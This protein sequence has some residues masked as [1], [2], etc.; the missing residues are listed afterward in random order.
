MEQSIVGGLINFRGLVYSP[1][2]EQGVVFLFGRILEDLNMYIEEVRTKYPDCVAR[3]YTG[4]GWERVYIEFEFKSSDFQKHEHDKNE[5]NIIVCWEH[6]W[7]ECPLEVIELKSLIKELPSIEIE[8]PDKVIEK[9]EYSLEDHYKKSRVSKSTQLLYEKLHKEIG[10]IDEEIWRKFSKTMITYYSP[11]KLFVSVRFRK[12]SLHIHVFTNEEKL[13]GVK[14]IKNHTNWGEIKL[15][16]E[17]N[18]EMVVGVIK[19]SFEVMKQAIKNNI[20]TGWY[21]KTPLNKIPKKSL[22]QF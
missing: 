5:C 21:A 2:N 22:K 19:K 4:K 11:E 18:L 3:R 15:D 17:E 16:T 7:H 8:K 13:E 1:V 10:K 20:N 12:K 9:N 6:D 14:N